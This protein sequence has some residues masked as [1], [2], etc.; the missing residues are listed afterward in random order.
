MP[1][2]LIWK[3]Q[4]DVK[5]KIGLAFLLG[6]GVLTGVCAAIKTSKLASLASRSD[7]TWE[8]YNLYIWTG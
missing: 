2:T 8:T 1:I 6:C 3:L 5:K 7:L 4:L